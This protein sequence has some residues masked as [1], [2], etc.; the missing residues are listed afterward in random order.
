[1]HAK[2]P[3]SPASLEKR[4]IL[5]CF[6][7]WRRKAPLSAVRILS[8][9]RKPASKACLF[10]AIAQHA[11]KAESVFEDAQTLAFLDPRPLFPGHCLLIPKVHYATLPDLPAELL[12]P[13][14]ANAQ[15]LAAAIE[16]AMLAKGT[17][18]AINNRVRQSVPHLHAHIVPR[19]KKDGLKGFFWPR[20]PYK[21]DAEMRD[22]AEAIRTALKV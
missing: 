22:A 13:L 16:R 2:L 14:F 10:C 11:L 1:M 6:L 8:R 20:R 15:K 19:R 3:N 21:N 18:V 7:R 17:F 12:T 5:L 4:A 9:H